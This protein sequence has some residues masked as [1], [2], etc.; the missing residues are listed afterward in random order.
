MCRSAIPSFD[1]PMYKSI[2]HITLI[3]PS[4]LRALANGPEHAPVDLG[5]FVV[6]SFVLYSSNAAM[7][8]RRHLSILSKKCPPI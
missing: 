4:D 5:Y 8:G 6:S 3:H 1:E 2:Y 7:A